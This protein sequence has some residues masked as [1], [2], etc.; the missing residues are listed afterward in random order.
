MAFRLECEGR[1][2]RSWRVAQGL[3]QKLGAIALLGPQGRGWRAG[4][5]DLGLWQGPSRDWG[6]CPSLASS[7]P[8]WLVLLL[9][10]TTG[11]QRQRRPYHQAAA[12][13]RTGEG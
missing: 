12:G 2:P 7:F 5:W 11:S 9:S 1:A 10:K 4:L 3:G 6:Q 13:S 8:P